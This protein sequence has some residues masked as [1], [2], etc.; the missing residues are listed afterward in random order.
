MRSANCST[1]HQLL[2]STV[3]L[4]FKKSFAIQLM[5]VYSKI[6]LNSFKYPVK[7]SKLDNAITKEL[8]EKKV[9]IDSSVEI[10]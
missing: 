2:R 3:N 8:M 6:N 1:D 4:A 10:A 9:L 5:K 7:R